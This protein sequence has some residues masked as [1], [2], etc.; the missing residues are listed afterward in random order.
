[1]YCIGVFFSSR[2]RHTRYWRDWSSD[3]CSS[4]LKSIDEIPDKVDVVVVTVDLKFVPDL[5]R[6]AAKKDIHNF[7]IISGGGKELGGERATIEA[8]IR[9]LS[10]ELQIRIIDRKSTRLNSSHANISYAVF[11]LKKKKNLI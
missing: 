8:Q 6:S 1:M 9:E 10:K 7:V 11:C 3:V 4:D 5:L 2:R